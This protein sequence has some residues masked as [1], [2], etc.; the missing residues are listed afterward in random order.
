MIIELSN[1]K[2]S[3]LGKFILTVETENLVDNH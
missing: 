2:N 3:E 1:K